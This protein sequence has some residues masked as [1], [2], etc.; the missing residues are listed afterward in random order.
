MTALRLNS[1][2]IHLGLDATAVVQPAFTGE[3]SWYEDYAERNESDGKEG[4]LVT[5]HSFTESWT[6]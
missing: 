4:R 6:S 3:M 1:N 5:V 2:P